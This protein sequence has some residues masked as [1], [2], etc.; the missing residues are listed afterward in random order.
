MRP[1]S[2]SCVPNALGFGFAEDV[3]A[4]CILLI[5]LTLRE[6]VA[7]L[8][9]MLFEGGFS[10][11]NLV[12]EWVETG[13]VKVDAEQ[14]RSVVEDLQPFLSI[15]LIEWKQLVAGVPYKLVP[16]LEALPSGSASQ[17]EDQA[18]AAKDKSA[19]RDESQGDEVQ[20]NV[21]LRDR[22]TRSH[23]R[24]AVSNGRDHGHA[25]PPWAT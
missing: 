17:S 6:C 4:V 15:E 1:V 16:T 12:P 18:P 8:E 10:F 22:A 24:H 20:P 23:I 3:T 21:G 11:V 14:V 19:Q 2:R 7:V 25:Q 5:S 13:A 9:A